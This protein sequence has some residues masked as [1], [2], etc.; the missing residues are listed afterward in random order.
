[1]LINH[2]WEVKTATNIAQSCRVS[3]PI[4]ILLQKRKQNKKMFWNN[5]SCSERWPASSRGRKQAEVIGLSK[6]EL[7]KTC[8]KF[9]VSKVLKMFGNLRKL[10][11]SLP[12]NKLLQ[13]SNFLTFLTSK[14]SPKQTSHHTMAQVSALMQFCAAKS[15]RSAVASGKSFPFHFFVLLSIFCKKSKNML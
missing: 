13:I 5:D 11:F 1:V 7:R 2:Y 8:Y 6:L 3:D 10:V 4:H 12:C 15:C 14:C 9:E